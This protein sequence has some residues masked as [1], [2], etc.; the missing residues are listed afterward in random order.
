MT[1]LESLIALLDAVKAG[2]IPDDTETGAFKALG[3]AQMSRARSAYIG[4]LDAA[5][6]LHN[7]VLPGGEVDNAYQSRSLGSWTVKIGLL[8]KQ[9]KGVA[10]T[11]ARAWLIA[12]LEALIAMEEGK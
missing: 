1:K 6:A 9:H 11:F 12:I 7:A 8:D 10:D 2:D 5:L 4:S 3:F